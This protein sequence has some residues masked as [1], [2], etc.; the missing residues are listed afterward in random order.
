MERA[1]GLAG[2]A[3]VSKRAIIT[4]ASEGIGR[5]FA[6]ALAQRGYGVTAVARNEAR[7]LNLL[8]E[9]QGVGHG[10]VVA[11][12]GTTEGLQAVVE[13]LG[14]GH[15]DLL[16]NNAAFGAMGAFVDLPLERQIQMIRLN[17]EAVTVLA[18]AFLRQAVPGD[19]LV[20][21]S[22]ILGIIPQPHQ[23]VYSA[24]K[25]FVTAL[26]ETLWYQ[27][28]E[29][30]VHVLGLH[31]GPTDTGFGEK[32]GRDPRKQRPRVIRQRP[33]QVVKEALAALAR[34]R[35]PTVLTGVHNAAFASLSRLLPRRALLGAVARAG[36]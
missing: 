31:P 24:T 5:A 12:L 7:L 36:R 26:S 6:L 13:N 16:V 35:G 19:A 21:V 22:S 30:G 4:G 8:D 27:M 29:R 25:A 28:R 23:P 10:F 9:M 1:L 20:N 33:E 18:H 32:A 2:A 3:R 11:D 17:V 15:T 34:R 14:Q